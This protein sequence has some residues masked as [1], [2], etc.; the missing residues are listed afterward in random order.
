MAFEFAKAQ[1]ARSIQTD[2]EEKNPMYDLNV[3]LGFKPIPAWLIFA[4]EL[5][6]PAED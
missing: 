4:K 5:R 2:N 1:G 6:T 3:R